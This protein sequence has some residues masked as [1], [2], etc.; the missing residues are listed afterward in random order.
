MLGIALAL[1][2]QLYARDTS[3]M[4][5]SDRR[6]Q[7]LQIHI[8]IACGPGGFVPCLSADQVERAAPSGHLVHRYE[9]GLFPY[10]IRPARPG[11]LENRALGLL[12]SS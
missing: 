7:V 12:S 5:V 6:R 9:N 11:L 10:P 4:I 2:H 3:H 8:A 1:K